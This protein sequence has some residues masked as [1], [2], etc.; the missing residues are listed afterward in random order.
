M[1]SKLS[2]SIS[3]FYSKKMETINNVLNFSNQTEMFKILTGM[4]YNTFNIIGK[5]LIDEFE[6]VDLD[7]LVE[8]IKNLDDLYIE[9]LRMKVYFDRSL[10]NT[11]RDKIFDKYEQKLIQKTDNA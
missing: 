3:I 7:N 1:F 6:D 9:Y 10:I 11:L 2:P 5:I 8:I 4:E